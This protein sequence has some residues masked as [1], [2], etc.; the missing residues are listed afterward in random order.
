MTAAPVTIVCANCGAK[1]KL[2]A[3]FKAASA[4]CKGCGAVID[5]AGQLRSAAAPAARAASRA[6]ARAASSPVA[7][8][9]SAA[10]KV[11]RASATRGRASSGGSRRS[12][13]S[14]GDSAPAGRRGKAEPTKSGGNKVILLGSLVAIVAL[15]VVGYFVIFRKDPAPSP[16]ETAGAVDAAAKD[17]VM[18]KSDAGDNGK[19]E[20]DAAAALEEKANA[21]GATEGAPPEGADGGKKT[22]TKDEP[23]KKVEPTKGEKAPLTA[24]DVFDPSTLEPLQYPDYADEELRK[25]IDSL[26]ADLRNGGRAGINAKRRLEE[27]GHPAIVGVVNLY[28]KIDFKDPNQ[29]MFAF[30][31]NKFLTNAFGAGLIGP[32][33]RPT[34]AGEPIP[35]ETADWNGKTVKSWQRFWEKNSDKDAWEQFVKNRKEGKKPDAGDGK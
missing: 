19:A 7:K 35:M 30:E 2:P 31:V 25:E 1:Y 34:Q 17:A 23:A 33:F 5:V 32:D 6:P 18:T 22:D 10:K 14:D 12:R 29:A 8:K 24:A 21:G 27:I 3:D 11:E 28:Q 20:A 16:T 13:G 4:K 26:C 9:D 15:G